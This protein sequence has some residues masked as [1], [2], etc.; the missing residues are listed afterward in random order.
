VGAAG[1]VAEPHAVQAVLDANAAAAAPA[2]EE[3]KEVKP[4]ELPPRK[5]G[6][7]RRIIPSVVADGAAKQGAEGETAS[8]AE[9]AAPEEG[10]PAGAGPAEGAAAEAAP[11]VG[12][13]VEEITAARE[14][15]GAGAGAGAEEPGK[16]KKRRV[17]VPTLVTAAP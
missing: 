3:K 5:D 7:K 4:A 2:E 8:A 16:E 14:G 15:V 11:D 10:D 1:A 12:A 13:A 17:I 9:G 6:R